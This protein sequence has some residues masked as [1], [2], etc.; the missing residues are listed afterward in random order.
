MNKLQAAFTPNA[1]LSKT[2]MHIIAVAWA[3]GFLLLWTANPF[4]II[5]KP[6]EALFAF[7]DVWEQGMG[8]HLYTSLMTNL[9][10]ICLTTIISL[11]LAYLS[12]LP[13]CRPFVVGV[14]KA[15]FL[16]LVGITFLFTLMVGS[17][18]ALKIALLTLGMTVFFVTSM[19][20]EVASIPKN[21]FDHAATL[22]MS[23]WRIVWEVVV[24]GTIDKAIEIMR[25]NAAMGWMMLTMVEGLVRSDGGI[26]VM[27]LN[28]NKHFALAAVFAL[29]ISILFVGIAQD[30][31][32]GFFRRVVCPYAELELE[33][34]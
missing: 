29:Q 22:R 10:A 5:P 20:Q 15:R 1:A 7:K 4:P 34:R 13:A 24:L 33:K 19:A 27:L 6:L 32:I 31:A 18:H 28:E 12:V 25:Q 2:A 30:Y 17:G 3:V 16:G 11:G 26:G 14:S 21:A 8:V 9:E 23:R